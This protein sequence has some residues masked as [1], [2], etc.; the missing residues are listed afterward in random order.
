MILLITNDT[1]E[2]VVGGITRCHS[3]EASIRYSVCKTNR[4][5]AIWAFEY[6]FKIFQVLFVAP[7]FACNWNSCFCDF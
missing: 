5:P 3:S 1:E 6:H 4:I 7:F 2:E